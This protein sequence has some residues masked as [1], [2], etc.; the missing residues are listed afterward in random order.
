MLEVLHGANVWEWHS[1]IRRLVG[2]RSV[3]NIVLRMSMGGT[4]RRGRIAKTEQL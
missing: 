1:T 2:V 4:A 3:H